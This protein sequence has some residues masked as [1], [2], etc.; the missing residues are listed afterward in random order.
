MLVAAGASPA[1]VGRAL[2]AASPA[3][4]REHLQTAEP[5][6]LRRFALTLF[7]RSFAITYLLEAI[8][9]VVGLAGV[10]AT[11][12]AQAIARTREFGMLRHLGVSRL[13]IVTMLGSEGALLGLVGSL[14]G[15][16]LG[17]GI[18]QVLIHVVNPQ[19]FNW[20]MSTRFP[21]GLMASVIAALT[22]A[23][24]ITAMLAGKRALSV[25]AVRAVRADW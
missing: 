6:T 7:D 17:A 20:T 25:D 16:A 4:L 9:I 3:D 1:Q 2:I 13:Q 24:T 21:V 19:S 22:L 10:A 8:A 18:S 5:A 15:V 12:S 23:A 11:T 14:S